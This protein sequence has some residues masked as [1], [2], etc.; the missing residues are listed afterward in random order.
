VIESA[1]TTDTDTR[2][3]KRF[4]ELGKGGPQKNWSNSV[5]KSQEISAVRSFDNP[6]VFTVYPNQF[7]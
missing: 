5:R 4:S 1:A 3:L 7:S 6:A 2:I